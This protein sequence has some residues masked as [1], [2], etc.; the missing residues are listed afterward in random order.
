M[1]LAWSE[2][3]FMCL[4][5]VKTIDNKPVLRRPLYLLCGS[6][7]GAL[8]L[9]AAVLYP[10]IAAFTMSPALMAGIG[11]GIIA[12]AI[13]GLCLVTLRLIAQA[14]TIQLGGISAGDNSTSFDSRR[15]IWFNVPNNSSANQLAPSLSGH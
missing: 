5:H 11:L 15:G 3:S 1:A 12:L 9:Y 8:L 14:P 13:A 4:S 7:S 10:G 2:Y 6:V